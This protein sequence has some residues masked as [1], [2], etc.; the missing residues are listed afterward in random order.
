[1]RGEVRGTPGSF[2]DTGVV[3]E[4]EAD[5]GEGV[6]IGPEC[7]IGPLARI[8]PGTRLGP[9]VPIGTFVELKNAK[10]GA[11]SKAQHQAYFGDVQIGEECN[12]GAGA[13]TCN[14]DGAE[15]HETKIGDPVFIGSN[16]TLIVPLTVENDA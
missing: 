1:M 15:K 14:D 3:F 10:I 8:R 4:G 11:R 13:I 12:I 9:Q 2:V 7:R 6:S 5:L 16:V